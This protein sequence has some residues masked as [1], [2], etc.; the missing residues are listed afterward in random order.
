MKKIWNIL[1]VFVFFFGGCNYLDLV[2]ED[3]I[4]TVE[5]IFEKRNNAEKWLKSCYSFMLN[6]VGSVTYDAAILGADELVSG[7]YLRMQQ[8]PGAYHGLFIGDGLQM[9]QE[10]Y[11]SLWETSGYYTAIRYCNIFIDQVDGVYDMT[12]AEK[13]LW[14]AE[15]KALKAHYYFE[16]LRRYG[17]IILVPQNID[18]TSS[19]FVMQQPRSPFDDCVEAI[20]SLVDEA[21]EDLLPMKQRDASRL[22]YYSQEAAAT[23]KAKALL[24]AASPLFNGNP[25]YANLK[26][27]EGKPLFSS[28][29]D[30]EKWK[31]AAL[32]ADTAIFICDEGGV[33]L[34]QGSSTLATDLLNTMNDIEYSV[35][36]PAYNNEEVIY[37]IRGANAPTHIFSYL[38]LP[39]ILNEVDRTQYHSS[40]KGCVAPSMKM[41][42]M[43]YTDHGLPID[44]DKEWDYASRYQMGKEVNAQ[45]RDVVP[46]NTDVLNLHLRREPRF[47][48]CIA[49]DRCYWQR[50][51]ASSNLLQVTA[52]RGE[53]FGTH[54]EKVSSSEPQNLTGYWLKKFIYSNTTGANYASALS[55]QGL[56]IMRLPEL[57]LMRA[58]AWN[59][60][61][62]PSQERVYD[63]LNIIRQRAGIP[64]VEVAWT[65]YSKNPG[66]INSKEGMREIIHREW[67]VEFAFEGRRFW[68]LRRWMTA[69]TELNE[70]QFGWN[71]IGENARA[72]YNNYEGPIPVWTKRKFLAPRD[73]LFPLR[74]EEVLVSGMVQNLGW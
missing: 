62:G 27:K 41:V 39:Y 46:V 56:I 40:I 3:D 23:L 43:Y 74:S 61:E 18:V 73:Y 72:F 64:D 70:S 48:A 11:G 55:E 49:A 66:K 65:Q 25:A 1:L 38:T 45:Y 69:H 57:Y 19:V 52:Y 12:V 9:A 21:M 22:T 14:K 6:S 54:A 24:Y 68:N 16:L 29:Y 58:E 20:V 60:Y 63:P 32:A 42:E 30:P 50:G 28:N 7:D 36:A 35:L 53:K 33:M 26:N 17:P 5:T 37:M 47:Y 15:I 51:P 10:P 59:E 44:Q 2:P 8:F 71:I 31:R 34:K 4:E 13:R 67:D